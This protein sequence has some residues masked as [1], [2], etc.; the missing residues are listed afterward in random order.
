MAASALSRSRRAALLGGRKPSKKNRSVGK[1]AIV[2]ATIAAQGPGSEVTA[3]PSATASATRLIAG[4]GDQR[5]AGVGDQRQ[6]LAL[7]HAPKRAR[8]RLGGVVLVIGDERGLDRVVVE[9]PARDAGV[10]GEDRIGGGERL[11]RPNG[12]VAEV[13][14]RRRDDVQARREFPPRAARPEH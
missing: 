11:E 6:R 5:R 13:A 12:D 1:P 8:A 14:D 3:I 7:P 4:V 9:Q 2:S 10:L